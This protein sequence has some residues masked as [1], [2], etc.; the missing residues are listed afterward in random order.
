MNLKRPYLLLFAFALLRRGANS[1]NTLL[2]LFHFI[3]KRLFAGGD[4]MSVHSGEFSEAMKIIKKA[5]NDMKFG[6]ITLM[7]QDGHIV[8]IESTE[9]YRVKI[10]SEKTDRKG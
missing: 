2:K 9:K 5:V 7:V 1:L 8:S 10:N 3:V 4:K 6:S